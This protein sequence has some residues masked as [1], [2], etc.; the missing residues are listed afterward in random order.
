ME[1]HKILTYLSIIH[2]GDW[3]LMYED[4]INRKTSYPDEVINKEVAKLKCNVLTIL[5]EN[6]PAYLKEGFKPPLVLY[7]YGDISLL[8]NDENTLGVVGSRATT[9]YGEEITTKIVS[10]LANDFIIVSGLAKGIDSIAHKAAISNGGKTIAVLGNAIDECYPK[11]NK[12]LYEIIKKEHLLISEIPPGARVGP[13]RFPFRNRLIAQLS[14]ALLV[15]EAK[16]RS[17]TSITVGFALNKGIE[18]M[19][20][21]HPA[22]TESLCNLLITEGADLVESAKDIRLELSGGR[23]RKYF[24][25][26]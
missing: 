16:Y 6:Y 2:A 9:P 21:P 4:L 11:E 7:Y 19:C 17:G 1:G 22:G 23:S 12:E 26:T 10:E 5:D 3:D 20:V 24:K 18:V 14:S 25:T 8:Y 15:T 13:E